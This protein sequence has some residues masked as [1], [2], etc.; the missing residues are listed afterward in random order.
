MFCRLWGGGN[1]HL[2]YLAKSL[3]EEVFTAIEKAKASISDCLG[4]KPLQFIPL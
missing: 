2:S 1:N 4:H 3:R